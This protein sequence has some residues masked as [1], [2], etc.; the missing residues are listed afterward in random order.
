MRI[1]KESH[2]KSEVFLMGIE[3]VGRGNPLPK[4]EGLLRILFLKLVANEGG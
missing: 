4:G 3:T 2:R 1:A